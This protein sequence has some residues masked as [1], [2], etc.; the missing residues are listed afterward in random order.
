MMLKRFAQRLTVLRRYWE[1]IGLRETLVVILCHFFDHKTVRRIRIANV[2]LW[3]RTQTPDLNLAGESLMDQ[4]YAAIQCVGP[5]VIVDAGANIG[6][7]AIYFA[8]RFPDAR[9][10][11]L[12][13][14]SENF[15]LLL[16]NTAPFKNII[17]IQAALWN[18]TEQRMLQ[19]R[20]NGPVGYTVS[21]TRTPSQATGQ[22]VRCLNIPAIV[23]EYQLR[24]I[25]LLKMDIEGGEKA[26]LEDASSW[27]GLVGILTVELHDRVCEGCEAAFYGATRHFHRFARTGDK[28]TAYRN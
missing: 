2:D 1:W 11:A 15:Q 24:S 17:P 5:E 13:P 8:R 6:T 14:E 27:I 4:E 23:G 25:D 22:L 3:V 21:T 19:D 10:F 26:V 20:G 9:I 28:I 16:K 7:S 12:E 18:R